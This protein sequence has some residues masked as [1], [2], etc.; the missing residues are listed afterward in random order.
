MKVKK[1]SN[2]TPA[3]T[4]QAPPEH[5]RAFDQLLDDAILGVQKKPKKRT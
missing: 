5:R 3:P 1:K 2:R 4:K